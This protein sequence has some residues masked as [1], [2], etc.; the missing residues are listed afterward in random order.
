MRFLM[1]VKGEESF[2]KSGPP[3]KALMD[4]IDKLCQEGMASGKIV[5][6]GGLKPT[7]LGVSVKIRNGKL[8]VTDGPFSESKEVIGG[9]TIMELPSTAAALDEAK[10]FMDVHVRLWPGWDG[11]CEVREMYGENEEPTF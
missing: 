11:E 3:P 7:S 9:F 6:L 10:A 5:S 4:A 1:M 8:N 2:E